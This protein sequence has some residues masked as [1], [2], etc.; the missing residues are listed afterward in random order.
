[1]IWPNLSQSALSKS[2]CK[3][4]RKIQRIKRRRRI[5]EEEE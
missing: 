4:R 1:L 2:G 5:E 3:R